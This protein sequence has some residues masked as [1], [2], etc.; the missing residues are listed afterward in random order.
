VQ[1]LRAELATCIFCDPCVT[2]VDLD[3]MDVGP[4]S[5]Q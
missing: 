4:Y 5:Y 1:V 3:Y 2:V